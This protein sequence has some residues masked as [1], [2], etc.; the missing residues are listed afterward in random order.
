MTAARSWLAPADGRP[1]LAENQ[2]GQASL[3]DATLGAASAPSA[4][5][6]SPAYRTYALWLLLVIYIFNF[7]DRS[8]VNILAEPIKE[9]LN[10]ADWQLGLM[11]GFA[12]AIFYTVLGLPIAR[13]AERRNR[14]VI[15]SISVAVWSAFT[16]ICGLAQNFIQLVLARIG[17]GVGEAGCT[18]PAHSLI[19][20]YVPKEQRASAL[21][22]Y[23][24]G[25]PLGGLVGLVVGG[26]VADAYGWRAAFFV[27]GIPG[28]F[29]AVLAFFTLVEPRTKAAMKAI[30]AAAPTASVREVVRA[31]MKKRTFWMISGA[32]AIIA[33]L[34]YGHSAFTASFFLRVHGPEVAALAAEF[35]LQSIGFLG[36]A[37]GLVGGLSGAVGAFV[38][39]L[40]ADRYGM[41]DLRAYMS[42]PAIA[43]LIS[44]VLYAFALTRDSAALTLGLLAINGVLAS[45][46]YGPVYATAQSI[47]P[48][49]MRATT[50]AVLLFIVNL[51]GLGL[52]PLLTG[53]L[54]D[55]L[56]A[57]MGPGEGIRW[58]L[59]GTGILAI[60]AFFFFWIARRSI[61]EDAVG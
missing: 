5:V 19:S 26:L 20:D 12:F 55:V 54:S 59:I 30:Q 9:E 40:I 61:R 13:L 7:I 44:M 32:V 2:I 49:H 15:I 8:V 18:P 27:C 23:S 52:G 57:S 28:L 46:W 16:A 37:L 22:F 47:V 42:V 43:G 41:R 21:A 17:V 35:G 36:L 39:G 60:P 14:A 4:P 25:T 48:A 11:S 31:L 34:G 58:S 1:K 56:A 53:L 45:L 6:V 29:L 50:A 24:M 10:L 51:I 3:T 33:F 38:G